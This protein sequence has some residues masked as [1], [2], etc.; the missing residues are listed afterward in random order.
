MLYDGKERERFQVTYGDAVFEQ[1]RS[2]GR[3]SEVDVASCCSPK[4]SLEGA[5]TLHVDHP[6]DETAD[7]MSYRPV[8]KDD[9]G[10]D[11]KNT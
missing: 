10:K 11:F 5:L 8:N 9:D 7:E 3:S 4:H 2:V 1:R 6:S